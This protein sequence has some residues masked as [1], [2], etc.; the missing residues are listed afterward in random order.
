MF[1]PIVVGATLTLYVQ[2]ALASPAEINIKSN[3]RHVQLKRRLLS[4][5][6]TYFTSPQGPLVSL[7]G[8]SERHPPPVV[9]FATRVNDVHEKLKLTGKGIKIGIVD[10][11]ID[12]DHPAFRDSSGVR[13]KIAFGHDFVGD[14]FNGKNKPVEGPYPNDYH[15]HGTAVAGII[16]AKTDTFVG[17]APDAILGAYRIAGCKAINQA[18]AHHMDIINVSMIISANYVTEDV[19]KAFETAASLNIA[20]LA[21]VGNRV[22]DSMWKNYFP[23]GLPSFTNNLFPYSTICANSQ[24]PVQTVENKQCK[25]KDNVAGHVALVNEF[26][27]SA[28][29]LIREAKL[30]RLLTIMCDIPFYAIISEISNMITPHVQQNPNIDWDFLDKTISI[31]LPEHIDNRTISSWGPTLKVQLNPDILAPGRN[32]FTTT[33]SSKKENYMLMSGTSMSSPYAAGIIALLFE[34]LG[35]NRLENKSRMPINGLKA[36]LRSSSVPLT[37]FDGKVLDSV[38]HQGA[39]LLNAWTLI[40]NATQVLPGA[41]ELSTE[42]FRRKKTI[43]PSGS[44][45]LV[46]R[47]TPSV[48]GI[49]FN[50]KSVFVPQ[51]SSASAKVVF[52]PNLIHVEAGNSRVVEIE[53]TE[54]SSLPLAENWVYSGFIAIDPGYSKGQVSSSAMHVPY[55]GL[56]GATQIVIKQMAKQA[57]ANNKLL[58]K[59]HG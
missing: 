18:I 57:Q 31:E 41:L 9:K 43:T 44:Y 3:S 48:R 11:G 4:D 32:L 14:K 49:N 6:L 56:K 58:L 52:K 45:T 10:T 19:L 17:V 53:I 33:L 8:S 30:N 22:E 27:C 38:A 34:K 39:G 2:S 37:S 15:G 13:S 40:A 7:K 59:N 21:S 51:H 35:V 46:H 24:P 26:H 28:S 12:Y 20:V 42:A 16:A 5:D 50:G 47:S 25:F 29:D 55:L 36:A 1:Y 54:P 23:S